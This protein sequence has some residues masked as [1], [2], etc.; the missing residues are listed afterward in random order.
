MWT[1]F[2]FAERPVKVRARGRVEE[3]RRRRREPGLLPP[4]AQDSPD[5]QPGTSSTANSERRKIVFF[6]KYLKIVIN[7]F[8]VYYPT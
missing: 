1:N 5:D 4:A 8:S 6:A 3:V 7:C 2:E